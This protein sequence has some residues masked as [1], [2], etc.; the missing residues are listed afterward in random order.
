MYKDSNYHLPVLYNEV[1][2]TLS[3]KP[4]GVYVDCTAGGGGHSS[5]IIKQLNEKGILI[6]IDQDSE[7]LLET[8]KKLESL[9]E[10][11]A[12][13]ILVQDKFSNIKEILTKLNI[14]RIDGVLADL[15][16]SSHQ[17]DTASRGFSFQKDG[18]LDMR[19]NSESG[20]NAYDFVNNASQEKLAEVIHVYGEEK[21]ADRIARNIVSKRALKPIQTT[22]ELVEI[23]KQVMPAKSKR[24]Q[25][26]A[27]RTFQA[28]RIYVNQE[29]DEIE[30]LLNDLPDCMAENGVI[31][32]ITFHS[33]EDRIVKHIF[34]KW[35]NPCTCPPDFP[36]CVCGKKPIGKILKRKGIVAQ[37]EEIQQNQ[38]SRSARLRVFK[39]N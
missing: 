21:F 34:Q 25:H 20:M 9:N 37:N 14:T 30:K 24:E 39:M 2:E 16:V 8:K 18:D 10:L 4:E 15:G 6:A 32:I 28:I 36:I 22:F 3:I 11:K 38:R 31:D 1:L 26:P 19:M 7:A 29:L 27:K 35:E 33:L 17:I 13:Y 12:Q 23:I 5:G